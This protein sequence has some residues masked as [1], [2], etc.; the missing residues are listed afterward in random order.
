MRVHS[1]RVGQLAQILDKID[2]SL[3]S[4]SCLASGCCGL[5]RWLGGG[6]GGVG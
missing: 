5:P 3:N 2:G 1:Q 6:G 4:R